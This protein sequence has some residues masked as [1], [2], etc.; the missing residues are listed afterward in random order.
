MRIF[1]SESQPDY[2][3]YTF[4]YGVYCLQE[5][6]D[7]V[8]QVYLQGFLP[9]SGSLGM[10]SGVYYLARSL[11]VDL[12]RFADSSENRRVDRKVVELG[13]EVEYL[14]KELVCADDPAFMPFCAEYA[15]A[16]MGDAM[17]LDRLRYIVELPL[18]NQVFRFSAHGRPVGYVL[19]AV[20]GPM[21][22][23]WFSFF[24]TD[25][26]QTHPLGKWMM[27]YVIRWASEHGLKHVY[28]GTAYGDKA[29]YK[30]RDHR[31][32]SFF[33]GAGWNSDME[34]LKSWCKSDGQMGPVDRFKQAPDL[35]RYLDDVLKID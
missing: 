19:T 10:R 18:G 28:L 15:A 8:P 24:D 30:V 17:S 3:T 7:E 5:S 35:N 13:V 25:L 32:L 21:L 4:N 22:H 29:L 1:F 12:E 23:Y 20:Y 9:F 26:M 33:D 2:G 31:G 16:R 14:T 11:R 6:E 27:W 34:L